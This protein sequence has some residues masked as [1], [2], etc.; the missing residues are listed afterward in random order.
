[1]DDA[2]RYIK[3]LASNYRTKLDDIN[4][5]ESIEEAY[6]SIKSGR[7][8][9]E[10]IVKYI[11][12]Q[13]RPSYIEP[14]TIGCY[15]FGCFQRTYGEIS[16]SCSPLC[17]DSIQSNDEELGTINCKNQIWIQT[18]E[19][20]NQRLKKLGNSNA[21]K[22]Y[23]YVDQNFDGLYT[24]EF[25]ILKKNG[26][27]HAQILITSGLKHHNITGMKKLEDL[28]MSDKDNKLYSYITPKSEN[29]SFDDLADNTNYYIIISIIA[30]I[31]I[32]FAYS[33][34]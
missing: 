19:Y 33:K 17:M 12:Q 7:Y 9:R 14:G 21:V 31:I 4:N 13:Y 26:V 15:L 3:L 20:N 34:N 16:R 27:N 2:E 18:S 8:P 1:M 23:I 24:K 25:N 28:P 32:V 5:D 22:A 29:I 11:L 30:V 10:L 6:N